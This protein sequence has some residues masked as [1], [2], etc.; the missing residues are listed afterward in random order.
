MAR[1]RTIKPQFWEDE[2]IGQLSIK[3]RLLYIGIWNFA[4][5]EGVII[6]R[7]EY[8]RSRI[9]PY[10]DFSLNEIKKL[11][12]EL[13]SANLL[14]SYKDSTDIYAVVLNF[15][16]HQVINRPV[17][18]HLPAP[19][20][21]NANYKNAI[22]KRDHF[23]CAYCGKV[24][25]AH[26][27]AEAQTTGLSIDHIIP[28]SKGGSDYPSN[29]T[30]SCASCNKSKCDNSVNNHGTVSDKSVTDKEEGIGIRNIE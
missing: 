21:Q 8:I 27:P 10:D 26:S 28:R 24:C 11:Q 23:L 22:F 4:D 14:Y 9:F 17:P 25:E 20:W 5:D 29:L 16:K 30:T 19:N 6:W 15:R 18:S 3:T 7:P 13:I 1:I 12:D 2:R